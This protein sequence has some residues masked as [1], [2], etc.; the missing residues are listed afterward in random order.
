MPSAGATCRKAGAYTVKK[1]T[2][3]C[4]INIEECRADQ[5]RRLL[6][7]HH[8]GKLTRDQDGEQPLDARILL[9][10]PARIFFIGGL[11]LLQRTFPGVS[12]IWHEVPRDGVTRRMR[13]LGCTT[14]A[15]AYKAGGKMARA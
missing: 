10:R 3:G 11:T 14:S 6:T 12:Q 7:Y 2:C 4:H 5:I 15:R 1:V 13:R 8:G 9:I